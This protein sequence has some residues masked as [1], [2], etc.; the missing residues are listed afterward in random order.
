MTN[1]RL[2]ALLLASLALLALPSPS[3][4][5]QNGTA[6]RPI[7]PCAALRVLDSDS[8]DLRCGTDLVRVRLRNVAAPRPGQPGY[9]EAVRGLA[10]LLRARELYVVSDVEGE[11]PLDANGRVLAYLCDRSGSNLNVALVLLGWAT[12]ST[13]AGAGRFEKSFRAAEQ[14]AHSERRALW[15]VWSGTASD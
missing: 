6:T 10:E 7:G 12:Y 1:R 8:T 4:R 11:L 13:E 5:A 15:T 14:E 3:A 2:L 9:S